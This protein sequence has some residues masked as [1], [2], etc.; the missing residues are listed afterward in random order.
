M[1]L[2]L[3][4]QPLPGAPFEHVFDGED[5][6][7]GRSS[8]CDLKLAGRYVS[9]L[10]AR[11]VSSGGEMLLEDLGSHNGTKLNGKRISGPTPIVPGDEISMPGF[12]LTVLEPVPPAL[13][14]SSSS[15]VSASSISGC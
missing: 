8:A 13:V 5:V 11:I 7:L 15:S 1:L 14:A 3:V 10:Q 6:T 2:R 4:I 12:R 9:R